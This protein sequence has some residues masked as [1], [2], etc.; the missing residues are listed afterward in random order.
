MQLETV[1][2]ELEALG[3]DMLVL[4]ADER[5]AL[6]ALRRKR[7]L[8]ARFLV[9]PEARELSKLGLA[10]EG[11][12]PGGRDIALPTQILIDREGRVLWT[13]RSTDVRERIERAALVQEIRRAVSEAH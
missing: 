8:G 10:H 13:F 7:S 9:D 1:R 12:G 5:D 2:P 11:A 4:A 6:A 3:V